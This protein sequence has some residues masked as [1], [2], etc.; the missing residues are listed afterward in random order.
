MTCCETS[1]G[2]GLVDVGADRKDRCPITTFHNRLFEAHL[3]VTDL[4]ERNRP[5]FPAIEGEVQKQLRRIE[6]GVT[7]ASR[8]NGDVSDILA[9]LGDPEYRS[10]EAGNCC[11]ASAGESP[12][13]LRRS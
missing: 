13:R 2:C 10:A 12:M 5:A 3:G 11:P 7:A 8:D 4:I 9:D 6:T 1:G